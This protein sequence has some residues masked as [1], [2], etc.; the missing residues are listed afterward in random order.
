MEGA[1]EK[2]GEKDV[3]VAIASSV[4]S[5]SEYCKGEGIEDEETWEERIIQTKDKYLS[6]LLVVSWCGLLSG[7]GFELVVVWRGACSDFGFGGFGVV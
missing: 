6:W 5:K 1:G 3:A 4:N 2:A 7:P